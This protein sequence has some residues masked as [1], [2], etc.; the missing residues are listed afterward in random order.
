LLRKS[1]ATPEA[2]SRLQTLKMPAPSEMRT[3]TQSRNPRASREVTMLADGETV[4][5]AYGAAVSGNVEP[6]ASM[7][8]PALEWR[9]V[10]RGHLW[11]RR[12]PS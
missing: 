8:D 1:G 5:A 9:G 10:S 6:L 11:W 7:L 12:T 2:T 3:S 4:R